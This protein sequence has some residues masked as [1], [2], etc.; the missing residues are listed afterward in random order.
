[1]EVH[2][3]GETK[4]I[5][6]NFNPFKNRGN[7]PYTGV[8]G[9]LGIQDNSNSYKE[10]DSNKSIDLNNRNSGTIKRKTLVYYQKKTKSSLNFRELSIVAI[11]EIKAE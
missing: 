3:L 7:S 5:I 4:N 8:N 11:E 2:S 6:N 10:A 1:M 9:L